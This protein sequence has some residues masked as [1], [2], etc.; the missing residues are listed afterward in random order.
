MSGGE[1]GG[2]AADTA[3]AERAGNK[4]SSI[5]AKLNALIEEARRRLR[6]RP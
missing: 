6:R 2:A 4:P 5:E 1:R 3:S